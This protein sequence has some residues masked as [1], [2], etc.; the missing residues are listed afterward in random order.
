MGSLGKMTRRRL[1]VLLFFFRI[2]LSKWRRTRRSFSFPSNARLVIFFSSRMKD[3]LMHLTNICQWEEGL[4]ED[5]KKRN[6]N[7]H[8]HLIRENELEMRLAWS[9]W[10]SMKTSSFENYKSEQLKW[11]WHCLHGTVTYG[12][13]L[14]RKS[15]LWFVSFF[16]KVN[17]LQSK[18]R[19]LMLA[20]YCLFL[21]VCRD[22]E[23][24]LVLLH[25]SRAKRKRH[26]CSVFC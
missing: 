8:D 18:N 7:Q 11:M 25:V 6:E 4:M 26:T 17:S 15:S 24:A 20:V 22:L 10:S 2:L 23:I 16:Q 13:L 19:W 21:K 5:K 9:A 3:V 12:E 14:W 1:F